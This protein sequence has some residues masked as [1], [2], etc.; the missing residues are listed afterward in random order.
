[1]HI[2]KDTIAAIATAPGIGGVG[3]IRISGEKLLPLAQRLSQRSNIRARYAYLSSFYDH[4]KEVIDQGLLLFFPAPYSFTGEDVIEL[5]I[6][7]GPIV[8]NRLLREVLRQNIRLAL[9][10][11]FSQRSFLNNKIDLIQAESI[12]DLIEAPSEE[13]AKMASRSLQGEF[14]KKITLLQEDLSLIHI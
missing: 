1:M 8:L 4:N 5:H 13:A 10:G 7:G 12:A 9:P 11:E 14:S 3:I 6:H 2:N